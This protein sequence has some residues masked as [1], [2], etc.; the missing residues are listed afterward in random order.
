MD[1][2][3]S[4]DS[5]RVN[6][7]DFFVLRGIFGRSG[8]F[9][10]FDTGAS[11]PVVGVNNFFDKDDM[12]N[13]ENLEKIIRDEISIQKVAPRPIPLK[14]ANSQPVTTY[15]CVCHGVSIENTAEQEFYF[16]L[17]FDEISIPLLGSSFIDDCAY[18]HA[19]NGNVNITGMKKRAGANYYN[20]R[21]VLDFDKV[22]KEYEKRYPAV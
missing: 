9:F 2:I 1:L 11:C 4:F 10:L 18:N 8:L 3:A 7:F 12:E 22:A 21:N 16:D 14:A 17:S 20:G 13:K 5:Q 15:P 6:T 19:I